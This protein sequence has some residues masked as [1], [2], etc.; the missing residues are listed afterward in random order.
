MIHS[1]ISRRALL[2]SS[3][4]ALG[5]C[6][7]RKA[8]G[9]QGYCFVANQGSR[10]VAVVDLTNFRTRKQIPLEAAPAAVLYPYDPKLP[11]PSKPKVFVLAPDAGT[12]YEI[13]ASTL[14]VARQVRA[15]NQAIGMQLSPRN[16]ALWVLYRDPA[17]L[18][19]VPLA[20]MKTRRRI[21]L[22]LPPDGFDLS[23]LGQAAVAS[24]QQRS[25]ALLSLDSGAVVRTVAAGAEPSIVR[26]QF[27]GKQL[28][29]ASGPDRDITI[30]DVPTGKTVVRL[31]LPIEPR[32]FAFTSDGGQL[33]LTG[34][35]MDAVV[36]VYPY[37]TEVA[38]T[39]LAGH[40]PEAMA[41]T[42]SDVSPQYLLVANPQS[43]GLTVLDVETGRLVAVVQVGQ[44]PRRIVLTPDGQY[45]LVLNETSGDLAVVR[46]SALTPKQYRPPAPLFTMIAVGDRPVDAAV[47]TL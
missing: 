29:S 15:G 39:L 45:A 25:I 4:A 40:A 1:P 19:E 26:F 12:V 36:V 21:K 31:P 5:A 38:Q 9:I 8:T 3:A 43:N 30:F 37:Q 32:Q 41:V 24:R 20:S 22:A 10:S 18:V 11:A 23:I 42:P 13:D 16:D 47:V 28:L 17:S 35:G 7:R 6:G 14:A 46:I 44:R 33:F 34:E 27:D 2:V